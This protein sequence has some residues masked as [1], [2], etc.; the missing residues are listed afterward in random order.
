MARYYQSYNHYRLFHPEQARN[1]IDAAKRDAPNSEQINYLSGVLY[2]N[3]NKMEEARQD[4]HRVLTTGT[5]NCDAYNYL[6][7]IYIETDEAKAINYFLGMCSCAN[8]AI[9]NFERQ[10]ASVPKLDLEPADQESLRGKLQQKIAE[11]RKSASDQIT[12][13]ITLVDLAKDEKKDMYIRLMKETLQ[14]I[15]PPIAK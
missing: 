12:Y 11:G 2:F 1:L 3:A 6:G 13:A 7:L 15:S 8:T 14:K 10:L 9:R 4:F 5:S